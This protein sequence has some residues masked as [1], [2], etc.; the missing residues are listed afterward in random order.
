[1]STEQET[2]AKMFSS[3]AKVELLALFHAN[4]GLID[5]V[6]GVARRIGRTTGEIE[7]ELK[8]LLDLGVLHK[9]KVGQSE[10]IY[11]DAGRDGEIQEAIV[12]RLK[13]LGG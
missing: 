12:N 11:F 5:R 3:D 7:A 9:K 8:D 13:E 2:W 1:V 6:D 10:V 4:P